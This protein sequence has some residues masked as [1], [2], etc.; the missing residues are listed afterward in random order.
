MDIVGI[1]RVIY[2]IM[3]NIIIIIMIDNMWKCYTSSK[4]SLFYQPYISHMY[5]QSMK[6]FTSCQVYFTSKNRQSVY[7]NNIIN[8]YLRA[9][10]EWYGTS[11]WWYMVK[12]GVK[13]SGGGGIL[14]KSHPLKVM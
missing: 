3:L 14:T 8:T 5:S 9:Y 11:D 12:I 13:T 7:N 6:I 1:I 4:I 2:V 10:F